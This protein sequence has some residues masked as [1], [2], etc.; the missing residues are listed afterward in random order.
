MGNQR[1]ETTKH[2]DGFGV[3]VDNQADVSETWFTPWRESLYILWSETRQ[4]EPT[5]GLRP[6][7]TYTQT[8]LYAPLPHMNRCV[9]LYGCT[10]RMKFPQPCCE[11]S[12]NKERHGKEFSGLE[13][14][15]KMPLKVN[16]SAILNPAVKH[17]I[18]KCFGV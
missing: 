5:S 1:E 15:I 14:T 16:Y 9:L 12:I 8:G 6:L 4:R 17:Y 11:A 2:M 7:L 18:L 3:C 10:T 13:T